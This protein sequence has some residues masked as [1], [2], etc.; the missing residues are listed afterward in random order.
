MNRSVDLVINTFERTYRNVLKPGFF[1]SVETQN[2]R[3]FVRKIAVIGNVANKREARERA[4]TL[5]RLGEIDAYY[6][7]SEHLDRALD[8]VGLTK[9]DLGRI[10]YYTDWALVAVTIPASSYLL[11][12]DA[13]V[14][15]RRPTNWV[16]PAIELMDRDSRVLVANP[17][18]RQQTLQRETLWT[19]DDFAIGYGFSDQMFLV[20]GGELARPIYRSWCV[21]SLRYPMAYISSTFEMRVDAYMRTHRRLRATY[22]LAVYEHP[23]D[24]GASHPKSIGSWERVKL[25]RNR[26]L[27]E[28]LRRLPATNPCWS[29]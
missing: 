1:P 29:I 19:V 22:K 28:V 6:F 18:W 15:L 12:W 16:D 11:H 7:V 10:P 23:E 2:L 25:L 21:A 4:E 13:E 3:S 14:S 26:G 8:K 24:E 5:R 27:M 17:N 20:R 9:H